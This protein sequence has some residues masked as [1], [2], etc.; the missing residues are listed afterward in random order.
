MTASARA[1]LYTAEA[2]AAAMITCARHAEH[3]GLRVVTM[4]DENPAGPEAGAGVG[5]GGSRLR[6]LVARLGQGEFEVIVADA[7]VGQ[8]LILQP[9][10][11]V[12]PIQPIQG[13][14]Q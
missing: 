7:G 8:L 9:V 6:A 2:P 12:Q 13:V 1:A 14:L 11:P 10:K 4:V 5:L 3:I